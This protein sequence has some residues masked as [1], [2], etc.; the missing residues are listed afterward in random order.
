M[1]RIFKH[2][3]FFVPGRAC[4]NWTYT[5]VKMFKSITCKDLPTQICKVQG[6]TQM[7]KYTKTWEVP[8]MWFK[9]CN[10]TLSCNSNSA[11]QL[12]T[13]HYFWS[14]NLQLPILSHATAVS[15]PCYSHPGFPFW[16]TA[17]EIIYKAGCDADQLFLRISL[18][19]WHSP[20]PKEDRRY[21]MN[22]IYS[23]LKNFL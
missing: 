20:P 9:Q 21:L 17:G 15:H 6:F 4:S 10:K 16:I 23:L 8:P 18:E 11:A 1:F 5:T 12:N 22:S 19:S 7:G 2:S 13:C 3:F 14:K